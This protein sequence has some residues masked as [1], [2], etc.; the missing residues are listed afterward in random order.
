MPEIFRSR[1]EEAANTLTHGLGAVLS[2][3]AG[4][5]LV[6]LAARTHDP[7]RIVSAAVFSA[8]LVLLY[9]AST[10]YH[11]APAGRAKDRLEILDHCAI[12]L[13]IAG[14][15]TPF[16][17]VTL[18]GAWGWSLFAVVWALAVA[19]VVFK[20]IFSTRFAIISTLLYIAMGWLVVVAAGP[21]ISALPWVAVVLL[22]S[23]GVAYT[24]GT[25]FYHSRRIPYAHAI[26]HLFVLTGSTLHFLA[27]GTQLLG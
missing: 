19:G 12:F 17:L 15:Y 8:A 21:M 14:T 26:W 23:G 22:V 24:A 7:W 10:L 5:M 18:R 1:R 3:L 4:A 6:A 9:S 13:L 25:L 20:L 2:A 11:G 16:T 27:V